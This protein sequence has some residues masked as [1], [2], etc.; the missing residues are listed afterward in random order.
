MDITLRAQQ[1]RPTGS[2][3][4]RRMR[5][6][7]QVPAVAYGRDLEP[8]TIAV[9][10]REL[11]AALHTEAGLNALINLEIDGGG[12]QLTMAKQL[13]RHPVRGDIIHVD[14]VTI[15]LTE[16]VRADVPIV[17]RGEPVGVVEG[18]IVETVRATVDIEALPTDIPPNITVD[19]SHLEVGSTLTVAD[20]PELSGVTYLED[21]TAAVVTITLP[22]AVLA[23][24]EEE[25]VLE[26]ELLEG[27][28]APEEAPEEGAREAEERGGEE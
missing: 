25:E 10:G 20:L 5:R 6:E 13:Q 15:S 7:G 17:L 16:A 24:E 12:T 11:H 28:E 2:R 22:A 4:S 27:E 8:V 26:E 21:P 23:E 14:F 9:D 18:G 19:I 3:S 1:G